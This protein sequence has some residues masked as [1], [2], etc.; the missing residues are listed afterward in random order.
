MLTARARFSSLAS[1]LLRINS[2]QRAIISG[3]VQVSTSTSLVMPLTLQ[4]I[5]TAHSTVLK[6]T[7][8]AIV[9]P[10]IQSHPLPLESLSP[11]LEHYKDSTTAAT[12]LELH[13]KMTHTVG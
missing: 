3:F 1:E 9:D 4:F 12:K 7:R 8:F 11:F 10:E 2:P 6:Q 13:V 5:S